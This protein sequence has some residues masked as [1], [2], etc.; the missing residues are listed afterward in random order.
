MSATSFGA[1][2]DANPGAIITANAITSDASA[3]ATGTAAWFAL[4]TQ[5]AGTLI[6]MGSV[7]VA[8]C[9]MIVNTTAFTAGSQVACSS[10]TVTMP[11]S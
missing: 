10:F 3:N 11:E 7:G 2:T 4:I 8:T 9:D 5:D 6:A 1:A